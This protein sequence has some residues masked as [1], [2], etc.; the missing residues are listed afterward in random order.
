MYILPIFL[1]LLN[2]PSSM[3]TCLW[4]GRKG[5]EE[6]PPST[7]GLNTL[8]AKVKRSNILKFIAFCLWGKK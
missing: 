4:S 8:G 6:N 3:R 7:T 1:T 5:S 2:L